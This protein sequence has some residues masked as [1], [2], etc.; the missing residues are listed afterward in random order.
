MITTKEKITSDLIYTCEPLIYSIINKY[1]F[2]FDKDDLYQVATLGLIYAYNHYKENKNTKF[3]TFAYFYIIGEVKKYIRESNFFKISKDLSK[4]GKKI[5]EVRVLLTN[6]NGKIP[7]NYE[8]A[9]FLK[10]D[11]AKIEE[12]ISANNLLKSLDYMDE[13]EISMYEKVGFTEQGYNEEILDLKEEIK[14]LTP[15][16]KRLIKER[17]EKGHTQNETSKILGISQV[18][19]SRKEKEIL[20]RL[21]TRL[22]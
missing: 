20:T 16:E 10:I 19:V 12:A 13:E 3:S 8:I 5:E 15:S 7:S 14:N 4:I 6:Q 1:T 2:Y 22:Q 18:Q 17:Y 9:N 21:R 11:I